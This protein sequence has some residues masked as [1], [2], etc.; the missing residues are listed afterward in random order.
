MITQAFKRWLHTMFAWWPRKKRIEPVPIVE[1]TALPY[2]GYTRE[3]TSRSVDG[4]AHT[5]IP[6]TAQPIA[7]T[8]H[9]ADERAIPIPLSSP[10]NP[11]EKALSSNK[12]SP[13]PVSSEAM[14]TATSE[15]QQLEFLYF[16]VKRGVFNEGF[17]PDHTPEQYQR[18]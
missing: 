17:P 4:S 16:L 7:P 13:H 8:A 3:T 18:P 11:D 2:Q 15:E 14:D 5:H 10:P 6:P 9:P 1:A 12:L